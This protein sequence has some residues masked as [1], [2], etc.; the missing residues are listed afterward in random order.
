MKRLRASIAPSA[1]GFPEK[2]KKV[3]F[4]MVSPN[5]F[6]AVTG[7]YPRRIPYAAAGT[8]AVTPVTL[9]RLSLLAVKSPAKWLIF[10]VPSGHGRHHT[11][12]CHAALATFWAMILAGG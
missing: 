10:L 4:A 2:V 12:R 5:C 3:C 9:T 6:Q 7:S 11:R 8:G 1:N